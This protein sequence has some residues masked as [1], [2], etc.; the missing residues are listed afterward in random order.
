MPRASQRED[1]IELRHSI[2]R[3]ADAARDWISER[4]TFWFLA[5]SDA[6]HEA[7][8]DEPHRL[9]GI[10]AGPGIILSRAVAMPRFLRALRGMRRDR[11]ESRIRAAIDRCA[12]GTWARES[13]QKK[14]ARPMRSTTITVR[15]STRTICGEST[16]GRSQSRRGHL[17]LGRRQRCDV[18][19]DAVHAP[20]HLD[21]LIEGEVVGE[22]GQDV[23]THGHVHGELRELGIAQARVRD[24]VGHHA[25]DNRGDLLFELVIRIILIDDV[26]DALR[27]RRRFT[28]SNISFS[29]FSSSSIA[30][31][32]ASTD[33]RTWK[34]TWQASGFKPRDHV[35]NARSCHR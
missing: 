9:V 8:V 28:S 27:L 6:V 5:F 11:V 13:E 18:G 12:M 16:G 1:A 24:V 31:L 35:T 23:F 2:E 19:A 10:A 21:R 4:F 29:S 22:Q 30:N 32:T 33:M 25:V 20:H 26:V 15:Q 7:V 3:V 14:I 34:S 17:R